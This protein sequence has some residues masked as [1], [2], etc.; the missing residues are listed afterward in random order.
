MVGACVLIESNSEQLQIPTIIMMK[1]LRSNLRVGACMAAFLALAGSAVLA[2]HSTLAAG[3]KNGGGGGGGGSTKVAEAR[4]T[5]YII[6]IDPVTQSVQIG[7]SYYGSGLLKVTSSTKISVG[8]SNG[9]LSDLKV[10]Q[11]AEA[12]YDF[13]TKIATKISIGPSSI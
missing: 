4:V 3:G 7:A 2:P 11:W 1:Q 12:R 8:T 9:S 5:G 13:A 6:S 10:G